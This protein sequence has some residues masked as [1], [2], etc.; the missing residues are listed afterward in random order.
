MDKLLLFHENGIYCPK[1][2]VYI[3]PWRPVDK[4]IITHA[5]ADHSRWGMKHY[6]AH[7]DSV[8]V[9][10]HRLGADINIDAVGYREPVYING[11]EFTLFPAGHIYG[12][13]QVRVS[14]KGEVWVVSGDYKT[15]PD[16]TCETFEPVQCQHFITESTFGLPVYKW[17]S[18][19][20]IF[21]DING[22]WAKNK[23]EGKTSILLGYS[24]GKAQRLIQNADLS[25][26]PI[27][28]H[29]AVENTNEVIRN[30]GFPLQKTERI[31][32]DTDKKKFPGS[33]VIAPPS[34][35]GTSW[36]NK[37][38]PYEV[39]IASGWMTLRGTRRRKNVDRGFALSDHADWPGLLEAIAATGAENIYV[40]HGYTNLFSQYLNE[41][42]YNASIV[43]TE[44][45]G[46]LSEI[47]EGKGEKEKEEMEA[48]G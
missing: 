43:E 3:D 17:Q 36:V 6:L 32:R 42:G 5:H 20:D 40:T 4:A 34:A 21:A 11:V 33:L 35:V 19:E 8:P 47:G 25:I 41:V 12:S 22:W 18:E 2:D 38:K 29:G 28:T 39:G 30:A 31:T 15:T 9:M 23:A 44:Y 24:L 46:E 1:A 13:A 45:T 26:G 37:M 27:F 48:E 10:R 7:T 16:K 14:Y